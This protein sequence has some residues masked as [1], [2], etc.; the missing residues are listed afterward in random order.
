MSFLD[1]FKPFIGWDLAKPGSD[2]T[3]IHGGVRFPKGTVVKCPECFMP[4]AM[5]SR[6]IMN[7]DRI[8]WDGWVAEMDLNNEAWQGFCP[9]CNEPLHRPH[10]KTGLVQFHTTE[11]WK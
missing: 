4:V 6:D 1:K 7:L 8:S 9:N 2:K 3:V 10:P 5:A 11:G